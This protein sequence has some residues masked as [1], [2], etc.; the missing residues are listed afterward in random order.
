M[1]LRRILCFT[2][3]LFGVI[4][5][6]AQTMPPL[7]LPGE[8][9]SPVNEEE[10][11]KGDVLTMGVGI[12]TNVD[13]NALN[14]NR[15]KVL[16][17]LTT[18][19]PHFGWTGSHPRTEWTVNYRPGYSI[20][21]QLPIYSSRSQ[22]LDSTFQWRPVRRLKLR[23]RESLLESTNP[24]D[25]LQSVEPAP[26]SPVINQPNSAI[27]T[28]AR[29]SSQHAGLDL[30]YATGPH[31]IIGASGSFFE[32]N[33][34]DPAS[35]RAFGGASSTAGQL[36]YNRKISPRQWVGIDYN[37]RELTAHAP[38]SRSLVQNIFA[39]YSVMLRPH[40]VL[41]GFAGPERS[42]THEST[43]SAT[44]PVRG[45]D[46]WAGGATYSWSSSRSGI[47]GSFSR[48]IS[49]GGGLAGIVRVS[50]ARAQVRHE[51]VPRWAA[52]LSLSYERNK[53]LST[54][55]NTLTYIS[56]AC[57]LSHS[58]RPDL[59]IDVR[60]WWVH[61]SAAGVQPALSAADHNRISIS[62]LYDLKSL[63]GK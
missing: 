51:F 52:D 17:V 36:F 54:A 1:T 60:Y 59:W 44:T 61:E 47:I 26:G 13:D 15:N 6:S 12:S 10:T 24:F 23:L 45:S 57:G 37:V 53:T 56:G 19:Q 63:L 58:L 8:I 25:R 14:D 55:T 2:I 39:T 20:S 49:D 5:L 30:I 40:T 35:S 38:D 46:H 42:T 21:H 48:Q 50:S 11:Y 43:L 22:Q 32:V 34:K 33:Y 18:V 29:T 3:Q 41:A 31:S 9:P 7:L 4:A 16:N 27:L 62:L 28:T